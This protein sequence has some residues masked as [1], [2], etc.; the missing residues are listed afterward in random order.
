L[1]ISE[2]ADVE[3]KFKGIGIRIED[4]IV[5]TESGHRNLTEVAPKEISDIEALMAK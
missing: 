3:Q 1:Y 4:N 2:S 5:L